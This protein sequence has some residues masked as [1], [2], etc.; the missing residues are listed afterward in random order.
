MY[1]V[2]YENGL[3]YGERN[4][5]YPRD[6]CLSRVMAS[7]Y[8]KNLMQL[9]QHAYACRDKYSVVSQVSYEVSARAPE[10]ERNGIARSGTLP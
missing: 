8:A 5:Q 7:T 2:N 9:D 4:R 3:Q 10:W 1:R 6:K